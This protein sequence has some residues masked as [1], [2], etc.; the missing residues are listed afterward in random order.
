M[1]P[2]VW[3][4]AISPAQRWQLLE[5]SHGAG[6]TVAHEARQ[7][8]RRFME[9]FGL[10]RVARCVR[11]NGGKVLSATVNDEESL[12]LFEVTAESVDYALDVVLRVPRSPIAEDILA[13][14]LDQLETCKARGELAPPEGLEAFD[15][16]ADAKL[17]EPA[18]E[19]PAVATNGA[20]APARP[21]GAVA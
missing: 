13:P 15:A 11:R 9:A 19:P 17:W 7:R 1:A 16:K 10:E 12:A 18:P 6:Q 14:L 5:L 21:G 2:Q 4:L 3:T 8:Y 20:G